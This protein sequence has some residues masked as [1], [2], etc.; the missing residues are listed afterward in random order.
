MMFMPGIA[1]CAGR[2]ASAVAA[3]RIRETRMVFIEC[4]FIDL[5][6]I[7]GVPPPWYRTNGLGLSS[8]RWRAEQAFP[9]A[10]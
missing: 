2:R 4:G 6:I 1:P 7:G 5:A 8:D 9:L 10:A 3:K